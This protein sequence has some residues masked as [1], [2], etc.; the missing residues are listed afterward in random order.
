MSRDITWEEWKN[1]DLEES[2][3]MLRDLNETYLVPGI[4]EFINQD[5]TPASDPEEPLPVYIIPD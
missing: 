2:M 3:N 4:E 5:T 1:N